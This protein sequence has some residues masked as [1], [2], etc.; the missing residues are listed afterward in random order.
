MYEWIKSHFLNYI[1]GSKFLR[2]LILLVFFSLLELVF[3]DQV[4]CAKFKPCKVKVLHGRTGKIRV[5]KVKARGCNNFGV[6]L[7]VQLH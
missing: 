3:A 1:N 4:P 2:F 6:F 5:K 7:K